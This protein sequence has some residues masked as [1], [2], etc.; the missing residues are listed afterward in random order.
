MSSKVDHNIRI[1]MPEPVFGLF[2]L[3]RMFNLQVEVYCYGL[4]KKGEK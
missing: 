4:R 3:T 1:F 2:I